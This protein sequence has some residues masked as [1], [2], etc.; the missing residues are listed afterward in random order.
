MCVV[1]T[2]VVLWVVDPGVVH[3]EAAFPAVTLVSALT[4][5]HVPAAGRPVETR[6]TDGQVF[7]QPVD[8]RVGAK[9]LFSLAWKENDKRFNN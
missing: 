3:T 9:I 2:D 4:R 8:D 7:S 1:L 6:H 5:H